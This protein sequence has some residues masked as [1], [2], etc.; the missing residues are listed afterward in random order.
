MPKCT[1][2]ILEQLM[3]MLSVML[4]FKNILISCSQEYLEVN[5]NLMQYYWEIVN[6]KSM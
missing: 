3:Y 4:I 2:I 6:L 1:S 5:R